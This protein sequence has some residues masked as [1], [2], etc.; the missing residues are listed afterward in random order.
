[1]ADTLYTLPSADERNLVEARAELR[2]EPMS[3]KW[4]TAEVVQAEHDRLASFAR[5]AAAAA[6]EVL[7]SRDTSGV[8]VASQVFAVKMV[9]LDDAMRDYTRR[10]NRGDVLPVA[11]DILATA[12]GANLA[13]LLTGMLRRVRGE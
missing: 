9:A 5:V 3:A 11:L 6:I 12:G 13:G 2:G 7:Q 1:M 8:D 10:T 4:W